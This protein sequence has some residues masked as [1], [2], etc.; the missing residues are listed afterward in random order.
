MYP[1]TEGSFAPRNGWYVAAHAGEIGR[2]PLARDILGEPVVMFRREDGRAVALG[3]RC[4]HRHYPLGCGRLEG[5]AI[6][7]GY[8]GLAF[9][10]DGQCS[11]IPTQDFVPAS[12]RIP[13]YP[14][15]EHG[16]WAF[17]WMGDPA[18][19][20]EGQLPP[21]G[22]I[23]LED[24]GIIGRGLF[25]D[26]V[27]ARYQLLNDNLLDLS[28]VA[29]L[30]SSTIG[31]TDDAKAEEVLETRDGFLSCRRYTRNT[32]APPVHATSGLYSGLV[33]RVLALDFYLPGLHAGFARTTYPR[34]HS[35]RAGEVVSGVYI[36]HGITPVSHRTCRY[37]FAVAM[38]SEEAIAD[39]AIHTRHIN[40]E[41]IFAAQQVEAMLGKLDSAPG[42]LL[43]R[44]D[45][46]AV[47]GRR[48][49]QAMMD[50]E[51]D[52]APS[53]MPSPALA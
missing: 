45:K 22:Q 9:G 50:R 19:A 40:N 30:H 41:D 25:V 7:C 34:D 8:H 14:L 15:V 35:E 11:H 28:H 31:T 16:L 21:L 33:D 38:H 39:M 2:T 42:D 13:V 1:F 47:Q 37:F 17:I 51:R 20:D 5:D 27:E 32:P 18:L 24:P 49:L 46:N 48:M 29:F 12:V 3:G 36:Y 26:E 52:S 43:L 44:A 4:P 10:T 23:G 6:V 53:T